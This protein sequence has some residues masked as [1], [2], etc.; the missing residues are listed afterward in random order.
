MIDS[1][2]HVEYFQSGNTAAKPGYRFS[3][4]QVSLNYHDLVKKEVGSST[5]CPGLISW[6]FQGIGI[7]F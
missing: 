7:K 5:N 6:S 1:I 4:L 2:F 3:C